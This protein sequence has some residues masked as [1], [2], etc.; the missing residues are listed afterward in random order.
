DVFSLGVLLYEIVAG[1]PPHHRGSLEETLATLEARPAAPSTRRRGATTDFDA[2]C[3]RALERKPEDRFESGSAFAAALEKAMGER[4]RRRRGR[5][6]LAGLVVAVAAGFAVAWE[7]ERAA[8]AETDP[9]AHPSAIAAAAVERAARLLAAD[10][11]RA[12]D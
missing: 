8:P 6:G 3:A 11:A 2:I 4:G 10:D 7:R 1:E 12:E 5:T 9:L